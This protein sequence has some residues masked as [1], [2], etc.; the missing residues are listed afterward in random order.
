MLLEVQADIQ[1]RLPQQ[2]IVGELKRDQQATDA[3]V[4]IEKWV[5]RLEL[6]VRECRLHERRRRFRFI[7]Q[8]ALEMLQAL[9]NFIRWR[10]DERSVTG[11]CPSDPDLAA[12]EFAGR[13]VRSASAAEQ[14]LV[15]FA[16]QAQRQWE[17][18]AKPLQPVFEGR[19]VAADL[20]GVLDRYAGL[21]VDL[22]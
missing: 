2:S 5:D 21:L 10:R 8:E 11:P 20:A 1:Q 14:D 22:V 3:S 4:A 13:C 12:S 16:E 17:S 18:S 15:Y 9:G 6:D 19:H 7:V